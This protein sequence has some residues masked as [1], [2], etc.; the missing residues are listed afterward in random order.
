M[1]AIKSLLH[2]ECHWL[3]P[4]AL[5]I[6]K[7]EVNKYKENYMLDLTLSGVLQFLCLWRPT[8][9]CPICSAECWEKSRAMMFFG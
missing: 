2:L 5:D 3:M 8:V 4:Y 7:I 1:M 9:L 6:G